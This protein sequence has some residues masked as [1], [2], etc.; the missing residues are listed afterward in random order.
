MALG[1]GSDGRFAVTHGRSLTREY[2]TWADM[3]YRCN[4]PSAPNFSYYGGRGIRVCDRW[5]EFELFLEDMGP[6]PADMSIERKDVNGHYEPSN[7]RWATAREQ[8]R[9]RRNTRRVTINGATK[10]LKEWC[11]EFGMS[12]AM[13]A[14][15]WR[16]GWPEHA[17]FDLPRK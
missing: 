5:R 1:S 14:N 12:W 10:S 4:T 15:R 9:N 6:A 3:L 2:G 11:A 16:R 13:V 8:A 17:L 7:C